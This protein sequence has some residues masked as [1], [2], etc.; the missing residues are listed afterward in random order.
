MAAVEARAMGALVQDPVAV[1]SAV[2]RGTNAGVVVNSVLAG[3]AVEAGVAGALVDVS[4]A[5][6]AGESRAAATHAHAA[7]DQTQAA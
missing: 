2:A 7:V 3:A 5:V 6:L 4:F 1:A